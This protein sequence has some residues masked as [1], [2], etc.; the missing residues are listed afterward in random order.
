[1]IA[2]AAVALLA[3]AIPSAAVAYTSTGTSYALSAI[4]NGSGAQQD[5]RMSAFYTAYTDDQGG[6]TARIEYYRNYWNIG[7]FPSRGTVPTAANAIDFLPDVDGFTIVFTRLSSSGSAIYTYSLLSETLSEVA[8]V[9]APAVP[10]RRNPAIGGSTIVWEDAG[11]P[12]ASANEPDLVLASGG[13]TFRLTNDALADHNLNVSPDGGTIVWEKCAATCDVYA[14]T[15]SSSSW[16][17][18]PVATAG[19]D[20]IWPDTNGSRIVYASNAGGAYHVYVTTLGGTP[21]QLSVPGSVS[22]NH[23]AIAGNFVA[24]ESSNGTQ[25][26]IWVYDLTT[27]VARRITDTPESET[28]PDVTNATDAGNGQELNVVWQVI[29]ADAN[30]YGSFLPAESQPLF[31]DRF[32]QPLTASNDPA[33]PVLNTGK[34]G[35]VIPVKVQVSQGGTAITDMNAPGPVTIAVSKLASCSTSAG[36]DPIAVYADAGQ[37]SAG[38]N[39]FGYDALAQA[40]VYN[41]DTKAL[42]LVT[43]NCYRIDVSVNGTQVTNAF[44]VFQP[45]K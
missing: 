45:T 24:F 34:N 1:M 6:A 32:L 17:T 3:T 39:Q 2:V 25:T 9:T 22:E 5:P 33:N 21:M 38:T 42:G 30:I 12:G 41:L 7:I 15:G 14:A 18:T 28:L 35:R 16:V 26:D 20:E 4:D 19:A 29:E 31:T 13:T 27:N 11:A 44:A 36:S 37:S 40:W 43:G 23:P 10:D 8:P